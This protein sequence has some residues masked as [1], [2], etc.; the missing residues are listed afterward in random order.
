M[1]VM[2]LLWLVLGAPASYSE[3]GFSAGV[4]FG[5]FVGVIAGIAVVAGGFLKRADPQP[6]TKPFSSYQSQS[7]PPPSAPPPPPPA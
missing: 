7:T 5:L 3:V 4:S 1:V 2:A 6:A